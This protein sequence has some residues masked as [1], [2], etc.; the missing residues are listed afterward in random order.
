MNKLDLG[1]EVV[2]EALNSTGHIVE[3][4]RRWSGMGP[5]GQ[6]YRTYYAV[7]FTTGEYAPQTIELHA[8]DV[9]RVEHVQ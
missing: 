2:C 4:V 6:I 9:R 8:K 5:S 1:D 3:V 7:E